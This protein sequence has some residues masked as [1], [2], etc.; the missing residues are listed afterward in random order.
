MRKDTRLW[1]SPGVW[2]SGSAGQPLGQMIDDV[3]F[4][5]NPDYRTVVDDDRGIGGKEDFR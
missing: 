1:P 4:R 2:V 3:N 5:H